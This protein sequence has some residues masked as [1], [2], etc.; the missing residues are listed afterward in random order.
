MAA[1]TAQQIYDE[2]MAHARKEGGS[3]SNWYGGITSDIGTRLHSEH[4]VPREGHWFAWREAISSEHARS[5]E[6]ALLRNGMDGGTGGGD[7]TA[8]FVYAYKKTNITS[9]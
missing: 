2:I 3:L 8:L 6:A 7:N 5:A 4:G 9:P 1:K